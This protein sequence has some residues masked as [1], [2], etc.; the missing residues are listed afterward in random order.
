MF[1]E[2]GHEDYPRSSRSAMFPA[3]VCK[4]ISLRWSEEDRFCSA[5]SIN[6]SSLQDEN[7]V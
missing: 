1:I 7:P 4:S 3:I 6:I 2:T 5:R